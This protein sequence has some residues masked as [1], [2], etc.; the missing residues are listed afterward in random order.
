MRGGDEFVTG[1]GF[2][3]IGVLGV[4]GVLGVASIPTSPAA[5]DGFGA[6]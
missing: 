4:L 3:E 1:V 6:A 5:A 2:D